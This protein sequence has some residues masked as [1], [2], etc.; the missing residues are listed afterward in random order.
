MKVGKALK[1]TGTTKKLTHT[2]KHS[3]ERREQEG[4]LFSFI[5]TENKTKQNRRQFVTFSHFL[6]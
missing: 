3:H 2:S 4:Y 6:H 5:F 1:L